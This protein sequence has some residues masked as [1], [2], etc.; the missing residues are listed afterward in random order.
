LAESSLA[1]ALARQERAWS[2]RPLVRR[3]YREWFVLIAGRLSPLRPTVELGTGISR[4]REVVP[5][6][7]AT[8]VEPTPWAELVVDAHALPYDSGSVGNLVLV[9]V[10]HH[11]AHPA[12]FF[13]EA[14]RVLAPGGRIV[15]LDPYCSPLSTLVYRLGHHERTDLRAPPFERDGEVAHRPLES[16]QARA[17]LALFRRDPELAERW[18]ELQLVERQ[19]LALLAYPL[20]GGF[21]KKPLL[22]RVLW[23]PAAFAEKLLSPLA[24]LAA[25][26]CLVVLQR[27]Q[28]PGP[29]TSSTA[30]IPSATSRPPGTGRTS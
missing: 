13:D 23:R 26:R 11:L 1:E 30:A 18:P 20:S 4:F 24:P 2:E 25:F 29:E 15:I 14:V 5:D 21:T 28:A 12:R 17:T 8:D 19:L 6:A 22:P 10:F 9:D 3:L 7:I 16:N 27:R